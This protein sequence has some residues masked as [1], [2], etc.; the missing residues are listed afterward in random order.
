M[1]KAQITH[2]SAVLT[3]VQGEIRDR[4][5]KGQGGCQTS[6]TLHYSQWI[7]IQNSLGIVQ[8]DLISI[9]EPPSTG[10]P[11][12]SG[13]VLGRN[14]GHAL[15]PSK[16]WQVFSLR[17]RAHC[18]PPCCCRDSCADGNWCVLSFPTQLPQCSSGIASCIWKRMAAVALL[19]TRTKCWKNFLLLL[20]H[21]ASLQMP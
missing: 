20:G 16:T 15:C 8:M 21:S 10:I 5:I 3:E 9:G 11:E 17:P 19:Q 4:A 2:W 14:E 7:G 6:W 18:T 12:P 1:P 13:C